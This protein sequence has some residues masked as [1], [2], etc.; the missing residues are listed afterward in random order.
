MNVEY[1]QY[2]NIINVIALNKDLGADPHP[3]PITH[4]FVTFFFSSIWSK[5]ILHN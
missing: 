4:P 1:L 5:R 3:S 2:Y